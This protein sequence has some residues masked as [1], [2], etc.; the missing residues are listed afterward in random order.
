MIA[1]GVCHEAVKLPGQRVYCWW[2]ESAGLGR[3]IDTA[4]CVVSG[5]VQPPTGGKT[6]KT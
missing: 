1:T 5:S 4:A 3:T 2:T 6:Q